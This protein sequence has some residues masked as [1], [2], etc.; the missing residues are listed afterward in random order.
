MKAILRSFI[1]Q[2]E[3]LSMA[4]IAA[5]T[6]H[7][8][9]VA[10]VSFDVADLT[11]Q[12][13][14]R[15]LDITLIHD[16]NLE[17]DEQAKLLA[18]ANNKGGSD[19]KGDDQ[20]QEIEPTAASSSPQQHEETKQ[21]AADNTVVLQQQESTDSLRIASNLAQ[22]ESIPSTPLPQ[23]ISMAQQQIAQ[24][25]E[26][27]GQKDRSLS[28]HQRRKVISA[29]TKEHRFAQYLSSWR[30]KIERVGNLNYPD[31]ARRDKLYGTVL[32]HVAVRA[33]GSLEMIKVLRSSGKKILDDAAVRSVK[34]AAPYAAFPA[35]IR[36]DIDILDITRTFQ[37]RR[38]S[39]R[40]Q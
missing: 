31:Q 5:V 28:Q 1:H 33:N 12:Q 40:V 17:K 15:T 30:K 27:I 32:L 9:V 39:Q 7:L 2:H 38:G 8:L 22:F 29:S 21:Q 6:A 23:M 13:A 10:T 4:L 26:Q 18:Q 3:H 34:L 16:R 36:A 19:V 24:L 14:Q 35:E 20:L 25:T 37:F 11:T